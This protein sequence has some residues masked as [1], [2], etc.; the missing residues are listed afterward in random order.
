MVE[1]ISAIN[2]AVVASDATSSLTA[3]KAGPAGIHSI[4]D[5]CADSY[6]EKL[7]AARQEKVDNG[8]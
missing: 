3:L 7:A 1:A 6:V 8:E 2:S 5:E 4:T